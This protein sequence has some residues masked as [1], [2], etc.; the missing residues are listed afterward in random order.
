VSAHHFRREVETLSLE[1]RR[2]RLR[3]LIKE[4]LQETDNVERRV[5]LYHER[6]GRL[7]AN[8]FC[9]KREVQSSGGECEP[10]FDP[11]DG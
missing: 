9:R 5:E 6:R 11:E 10:G 8:S 7:C 1:E 4:I 3:K 2:A